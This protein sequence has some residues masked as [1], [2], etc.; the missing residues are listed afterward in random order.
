[1]KQQKFNK[2]IKEKRISIP[3]QQQQKKRNENLTR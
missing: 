2:Y 1:M 3:Q